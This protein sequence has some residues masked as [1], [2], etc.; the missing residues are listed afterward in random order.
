MMSESHDR[1]ALGRT[2]LSDFFELSETAADTHSWT[3]VSTDPDF[4][5][6]EDEL[7]RVLADRIVEHQCRGSPHLYAAWR[8]RVDE[9]EPLSDS[10]RRALAEGFL[11]PVCGLPEEPEAVSQDH[12]EG[13]VGEMLW[14]FLHLEVPPEEI[15]RVEPPG[16]A[17]TD[18]GGD[19]L[20][21]HR[22]QEGY[23]MFRLWEM[24]KCVGASTV[25]SAVNTAYNQLNALALEYLARYAT[26]GQELPHEEL[27]D[28]YSRLVDLWIDAR[29]EAAVGVSVATSHNHVP[30]RCFTTFGNHFPEF[31]DPLRLRGML[32]AISDFSSFSRKV[33][34]HVC[35]AL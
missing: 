7:A 13:F 35:G 23:L 18:R 9:G 20:A 8:Q 31:V 19:S 15:I 33:R 11:R 21:I 29:P 6:P 28:F 16:F 2:K 24:K 1:D 32:T 34:D 4:S 26:V 17:S 5:S 27:A 30:Q 12:L 14:Y 22:V 25:S 10:S 3:L